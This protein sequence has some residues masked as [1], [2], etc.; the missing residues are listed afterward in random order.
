[1]ETGD[2][3]GAY[4]RIQEGDPVAWAT[5]YSEGGKK[6]VNSG[7]IQKVGRH[8]LLLECGMCKK[9]GVTGEL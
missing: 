5:L 3:G 8:D 9:E 6:R 1:M 7:D 2:Q 4:G